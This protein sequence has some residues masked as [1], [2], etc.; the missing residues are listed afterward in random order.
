[1]SASL[2]YS[3]DFASTGDNASLSS[4]AKSA[5]L[6]TSKDTAAIAASASSSN[7]NDNSS[8]SSSSSSSTKAKSSISTSFAERYID[9]IA[10]SKTLKQ[11]RTIAEKHKKELLSEARHLR[12]Q[13]SEV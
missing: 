3:D 2:Y 4:A 10:P 7:T 5:F 9:E 6:S 1:M 11:Y 13:F 8:S 12:E